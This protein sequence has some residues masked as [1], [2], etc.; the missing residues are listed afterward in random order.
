MFLKHASSYKDR[1]G[2]VFQYQDKFFRCI[3]ASYHQNYQ[4]LMQSGLYD[5]LTKKKWLLTH[6]EVTD[7]PELNLPGKQIILPQQISVITYPYEWSFNMWQDAAL[8]TLNIAKESIAMGM[9]LKDATPFNI[10]FLNGTPFFIDTL[11]F[12]KYQPEKPWVAYRQ[13]CECFLAPLLLQQYCT[14]EAGKF[15]TIYPDGI[16]LN[17]VISLLPKK[18]K[19]NLHTWMHIYLQAGLQNKRRKSDGN[20]SGNFSKN[21]MLLLI[22][23]L[24]GYVTKLHL[25]KIRTTWD[26]YYSE[27]IL[28]E[29]YLLEKTKLVKS[30][31]SSILFLSVID[32]GANDGYFSL[33]F[34]NTETQ[35]IAVDGDANC[36]NELY[37]KIRHEKINNILPLINTLDYPSPAIGWNN[38][39]RASFSER[40]KGGVV[41]ALALVHH[42]AIAKNIPFDFIA[43]WL[44]QMGDYLLIEFVPKSDEKVQLLLQNRE[45]I[46]DDYTPGSFEL[47]FSKRFKTLLQQKIP[48]TDRV[49][50]LMKKSDENT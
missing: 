5:Q 22:N 2:F 32:L 7:I 25:K 47:S 38:A 31:L 33:L 8:L 30:F 16:P 29:S 44:A 15:F 37:K 13:F 48:G 43:G 26:N 46:F 11:S 23:G 35:I 18:A 45:D 9:M 34:K 1:D 6:R 39:A 40:I 28:S 19:W 14:A 17:V 21:K 42:L 3:N 50:Y 12:A 49:L 20:N 24:I 27:T 36:I 4:T 10:Q 41:F